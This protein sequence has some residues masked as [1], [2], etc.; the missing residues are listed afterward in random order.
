MFAIVLLICVVLILFVFVGLGIKLIVKKD[1]KF[2]KS[3]GS[4]DPKTGKKTS[5]S[6]GAQEED[7]CHNN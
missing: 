5:C 1:G 7:K 3:C 6:C 2:E 4:I